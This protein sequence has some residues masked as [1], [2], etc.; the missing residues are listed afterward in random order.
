[1]QRR[2]GGSLRLTAQTVAERLDVLATAAVLVALA[3][4]GFDAVLGDQGLALRRVALALRGEH[5]GA[6][7]KPDLTI[8]EG[9]AQAV[10]AAYQRSAYA[11]QSNLALVCASAD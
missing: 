10:E 3:A 9:L 11:A 7:G 8:I 1:V 6:A 4:T 5:A 2:A